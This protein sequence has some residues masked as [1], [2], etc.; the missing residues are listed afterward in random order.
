[1]TLIRP[2]VVFSVLTLACLSANGSII[3]FN[4]SNFDA[5]EA[6][7][8][9]G[10][11]GSSQLQTTSA[12]AGDL[13]V[14]GSGTPSTPGSPLDCTSADCASLTLTTL[15]GTTTYN[16][17]THTYN[18]TGGSPSSLVV[19]VTPASFSLSP[20][21]SGAFLS[22]G[23]ETTWDSATVTNVG[24]NEWMLNGVLTH[25]SNSSSMNDLLAKFGVAATPVLPFVYVN[26]LFNATQ[27]SS[28]AVPTLTSSQ[29]DSAL[30]EVS[31]TQLPEPGTLMLLA[32]GAA[33]LMLLHHHRERN[34]LAG[35]H[36]VIKI[37]PVVKTDIELV[38]VEPV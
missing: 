19:S 7:T 8:I 31:S 16:A 37:I 23:G 24:G 29:I 21:G 10:T 38:R 6:Q 11:T 15:G 12:I 28:G 17:V 36:L 33:G 3:Y 14:T 27:G 30:V 9:N 26:V 13:I 32:F 25:N 18:F 20:D 1:M 22:T 2:L 5:G 34:R 35:M 4:Y